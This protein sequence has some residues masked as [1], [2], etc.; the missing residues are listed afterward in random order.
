VRK[1]EY[2]L[3]V[4]PQGHI[5]LPKK[6]RDVFGNQMKFLPNATAAVIYP[7]NADLEDVV[8]SLKIIISD[9][10]LRK[11]RKGHG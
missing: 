2:E 1:V 10:E 3:K 9:M 4:G 7:D 11:K 5:Y 6:I 8:A